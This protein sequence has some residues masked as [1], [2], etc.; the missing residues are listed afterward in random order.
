MLKTAGFCVLCVLVL[1]GIGAMPSNGQ[2]LYGSIVGT[3]EDPTGAVVPKA[4][5]TVTNKATG[6]SRET[7]ADEGGRFS[8]VN[9]LPGS[10]EIKTTATGFRTVTR[11]DV[12]VTINNVSRVDMKLEVGQ[13]TEQVTVAGAGALLQTDKS[14]TRAELSPQVVTNMPL[15]NYRNYQSLINLVPGATPALFQNATVDSPARAMRTF[16]NGSNPNNNNTRVDGAT[17]VFLWL[18]HHTAYVQPVESIENV[19]ISTSNF[20][21]EQGM[22]GGAAITVVTKSGTND[23]HGVAFWYHDNQHLRARNFFLRTPDKPK[24]INNIVGGTLGGRIVKNKLFYF[25]SY[26][27]TMERSGQSSQSGGTAGNFSVPTAD[28]REG[29]FSG[30][31]TIIYDP[32]TGD[33][34]GRN[35]Q[36]FPNNIIPP[37]RHS[38]IWRRIQALIPQPNIP[39]Q[40]LNNY[41]VSGTQALDRDS[42]DGKLNWNASDNL[43]IWGKYSRMD[44]P[45][46]G[47]AALG[48]AGGPGLGTLGTGDTVVQI[49]TV[50][51]TWT[52][53]PSFLVDGVF[54]YTRFD[55]SVIGPDYGTNYGSEVWGIPGTNGPD[56]RQSGQPIIWESTSSYTQLGNPNGWM[57][58][59][60]NDRSFTFSTNAS[61]LSGAHEFRFGFDMVRHQMNHW[62]P[63]ISNGPRGYINFTGSAT[64]LNGGPSPDYLNAHAQALLGL[65]TQYQKAVQYLLMTPRE[66]QFGWYARDRWQATRK[67]TLNLGLRYEYYPLLTREDRGI[68]RWDPNTNIVTLGGIGG[69]PYSNGITTSKRLFAPRVGFAYRFNDETVIR[70]GYGITYDP[71]AFARPLRGLYPA[72]IG[73]TFNA[74]NTFAYYNR[75]D[76]GIPPVPLPDISSGSLPLPPNVD[77]G[78][79]S[80]WA[81][82]L[83][84]GYIQSWNFT[85][86]RKLPFDLIA[87]VAYVGTSTVHQLADRDINAP[88][89]GQGDA[90][91]PLAATQGR[92]ITANM[93]DGWLS[94]NY[95]GLQMA[96]NKQF[97]NGLLLK[98]AYTWSKA[99][100]MTDE[101]GWA[102]V[103]RNWG[104]EIPWNRA[105]SGQDRTQMFTMGWVYEL[106]LGRGKRWANS[107][108]SQ[109]L[110][111]G[112]QMNGTFG[113]YSG[114]PFNVTASGASVNAPNNTQTADQVGPIRKLGEVGP[115]GQF[116]DVTSFRP[117]T[118]VRFG[119]MGRNALRGPGMVNLNLS[120]F[121]TFAITEKLKM[122]FRAEAFNATNTPHFQNP[123]ANVS[124]ASFNPDG[125]VRSLGDFMSIRG[126]NPTGGNSDERQYRFGLRFAF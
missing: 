107:G 42:Y 113:A 124:N 108:A 10:Y 106:P 120:V 14:E 89:P 55:Q 40:D 76:Q 12:D 116:Y 51:F 53:S 21:A 105:V 74:P 41:A 125:T 67:L 24:S 22:A 57:P 50:G 82:E 121:R 49:P 47:I 23:T 80:P 122:E 26:E 98:G 81:G 104:P 70:S 4:T 112:W 111:G 16:V 31:S 115:G 61:K 36:P 62:Q 102:T 69:I 13:V 56:I 34:E 65:P 8:I 118:E 38:P 110:I 60:R 48:A 90:G 119:N 77:M 79:R 30:K 2:V 29:N 7:T 75:L 3:V 44:A 5:V 11:T 87:S 63:E 126:A 95:H 27:R 117:V 109:W 58:L 28:I 35:R 72:T 73:A 88:G 37:E 54:G 20:D 15:S 103:G 43:M 123:T 59:F 71:L 52:K 97:T 6:L 84:R 64:A 39:G 96:L 46:S 99:I 68:E 17:N 94:G 33:A 18:P 78:P 114:L 66:W 91:R 101:D 85:I 93:W 25:V 32:A 92:R 19:N 83:H 45:V 100:N 1:L 9:L 86:E